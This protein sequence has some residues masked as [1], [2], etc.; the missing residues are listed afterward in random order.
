MGLNL[1]EGNPT[2]LQDVNALIQQIKKHEVRKTGKKSQARRA[3]SLEEFLK[4]LAIVEGITPDEAKQTRFR[5][6]AM[7]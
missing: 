3:F 1:G 5:G 4:L 6:L 2:R 7:L